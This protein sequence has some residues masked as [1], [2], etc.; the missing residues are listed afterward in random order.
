MISIII[1]IYNVEKYLEKCIRSILTQTY[2]NF[3]V[4]LVNDGST[5]ASLSVCREWEKRDNRIH[6][7]S[8]KNGGV[9]S[10]RNAG[11]FA[12][13]GE[14]VTF[15]DPDDWIE[16]DM[17]KEMMKAIEKYKADAAFC[18]YYL[19]NLTGEHVFVTENEIPVY[20]DCTEAAYQMLQKGGYLTSVWNKLF[21]YEKILDDNAKP[22]LFD[23]KIIMSED[24]MWL[25]KVLP[26]MTKVAFISKPF[27]HWVRRSGTACTICLKDEYA[28]KHRQ[29][30]FFVSQYTKMI[31]EDNE[32]LRA[33]CNARIYNAGFLLVQGLY[34]IG[35]KN[36]AKVILDQIQEYQRV[37]MHL[38]VTSKKQRLRITVGI[39]LIKK[40]FP[41]QIVKIILN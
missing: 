3:E 15:V 25:D 33:I 24:E 28:I 40:N 7:I 23:N 13:K 36:E 16:P 26:Q 22:I 9:S 6:V 2:T 30:Q 34:Y 8:K 17:Y 27:Y 32:K 14:Y 19:N 4:I 18:S 29:N 10:A 12:V 1:P 20:G 41:K 5:D 31:Y 35:K 21:K 37:W 38:S 11:L 39:F